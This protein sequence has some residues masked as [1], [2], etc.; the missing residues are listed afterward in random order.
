MIT[1]PAH[2]AD[3]KL[4]LSLVEHAEALTGLYIKTLQ[5][6]S[7][8]LDQAK[9]CMRLADKLKITD[10]EFARDSAELEKRWTEGWLS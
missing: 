3:A 2:S 10:P 4:R 8:L 1:T 7:G 6:N 9:E 5:V